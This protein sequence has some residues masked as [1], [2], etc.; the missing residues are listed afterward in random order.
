[1]VEEELNYTDDES[2]ED[3][4]SDEEDEDS[5]DEA[6]TATVASTVSKNSKTS[7]VKSANSA[8]KVTTNV[9][10]SFLPPLN[11]KPSPSP[12]V[13]SIKSNSSL[14]RSSGSK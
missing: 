10:K 4:E 5:E 1:M 14:G 8:I 11:V 9:S 12:S 6:D 2:E 3:A 7:S 13:K